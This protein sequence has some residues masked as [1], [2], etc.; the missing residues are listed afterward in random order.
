MFGP[1]VLNE[2][3]IIVGREAKTSEL[4]QLQGQRRRERS[5]S[6][7][8]RLLHRLPLVPVPEKASLAW[9]TAPVIFYSVKDLNFLIWKHLKKKGRCPVFSFLPLWM[10]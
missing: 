7:L 1:L 4:I 5:R 8:Q 2:L 3:F 9:E 6:V 10:K